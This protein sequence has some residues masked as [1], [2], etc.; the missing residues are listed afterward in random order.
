MEMPCRMQDSRQADWIAVRRPEK[1]IQAELHKA[2]SWCISALMWAVIRRSGERSRTR[3]YR[4]TVK[5]SKCHVIRLQRHS[6]SWE[7]LKF[8]KEN[9]ILVNETWDKIGV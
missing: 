9:D 7:L 6:G 2:L 3:G 4:K 8:H 1:G 5:A